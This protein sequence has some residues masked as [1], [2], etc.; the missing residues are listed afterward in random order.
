MARYFV[1]REFACGCC[2]Q[3]PQD[4]MD[5]LLL[6][7]LD[8]LRHRLGKPLIVSSGYRCGAH[9]AAVGG[10][11]GSYHCRGLAADILA[12]EGVRV[13]EVADLA[14]SYGADGI[15]RYY[16]AGFVHVDVRGSWAEW[17]E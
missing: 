7:I 13:D 14:R 16:A 3:L 10:V 1:A 2:G 12:P 4:G 9:N 5:E 6:S 17:S 8:V 11:P 15:G